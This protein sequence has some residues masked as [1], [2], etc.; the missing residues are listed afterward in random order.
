MRRAVSLPHAEVSYLQWTPETRSRGTVALL[1]GGGLDSAELTWG[2][3]GV[4]L[5]NA[6]WRVLDS[7]DRR[8]G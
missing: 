8:V 1:H 5:A 3:I 2:P 7:L 4:A 6:G